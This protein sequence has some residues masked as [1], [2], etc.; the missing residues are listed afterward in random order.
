M[1]IH[2]RA[3]LAVLTMGVSTLG[4]SSA[5][6]SAQDV[7]INEFHYDNDGIDTGEAIEV[8]GV[9]GT[10]LTGWS[11]VLYN[12]STGAVYD[13]AALS[14]V[15]PQSCT[16]PEIGVTVA[17]FPTN[18]IQNGS[19]DGIALVSP[20]G[21]VVQ[22]L[23]YEGT[24]V[25]VGGPANGLLST[26]IGVSE[27]SATPIGD[28]LQ[29][30]ATGWAAG[31]STFGQCN[32]DQVEPPEL[33][34][35]FINEFHYDNGGIDTGEAIEVAGV[36]GTEVTGWSL[37]L[38]SGATGAV[39]DT[40][41]PSGVFPQSCTEPEVGVAVVSFPTNGIQNG[42]PDGIALVSPLGEVVQFLSYEGTFVAV[43][44][45]ANGQLSTD[46]GVSESSATPIGDS[47][48]LGTTGWAAGLS[49]FGQC[50]PDQVPT[51][52]DPGDPD[53][54]EA[55]VHEI[56]GSGPE[57]TDT[58][59]IFQVEAIV[60]GDFQQS[61]QLR[62]FFIQEEDADVDSDPLT[63][64]GIFV[65]CSDCPVDVNV[66]D[67]V[68][69]TGLASDGFDM[70]QLTATDPTSVQVT[71]VSQPL[72]TPSTIG[73]PLAIS[74]G[75][76][77]GAEQGIN[78][79][80]EAFEGMLVQFV[81]PLTVD[82]YFQLSRFGQ[83]VLS[84]GSRPRQF[85]DTQTPSE[86]G[87]TQH[88]I[89]LAARRVI[90]DDDNNDRDSALF[91]GTPVFH[92]QP[93]YSIDNF[94]RGGDVIGNLTGV[95][96]WSSAGVGGT[97]AWRVRPVVE[98]FSYDFDRSSPRSE[99]P[100]DVGGSLK[101]A[102]FNV[103]NFFTTIDD[104]TSICGPTGGLGCR[105]ASSEAELQ[106]QTDKLASAL[107]DI[108][109]DIVG[110]VELENNDTASLEALVAAVSSAGCGD[111]MF[112]DT[113]ATG[114]DAIKV[115]L[116][117]KLSAVDAI[118]LTAVLD[119]ASFTDPASTGQQKNRPAVAQTFAELSS[120]QLL[121]VVVNHLKS[122]GSGCGPG[123]DSPET[124]VGS[125]NLTR[126]LAAEVQVDWLAAD[127]TDTG[128]ENILIIG[129]L[130]AYRKE[131]PIA[132]FQ[133]GGYVD[134][135]DLF[136]GPDAYSFLFDGQLGTLDYALASEALTPKVTGVTA[137]H[138]NADEANLLDYNDTVRD[139]S[140]ASF[141]PK[142]SALP[143]FEPNEYRSSDHDPLV[144]GL[145]LGPGVPRC[146]GLDATIYVDENGTIVGGP[147]SGAVYRGVLGATQGNDVIV[148]SNGRDFIFSGGGNDTICAGG[149]NDFVLAGGGHDYV[150]GEEG[151]DTL[152]G[153]FGNDAL[154]GGLGDDLLIGGPGS[155]FV[156]GGED[157]D[158]CAFAFAVNCE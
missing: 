58:T 50:N 31:L 60:V 100:A 126:T 115:G 96:H 148:A 73:L 16:E 158:F 35:V 130:N 38:Y 104:G 138:I 19:P 28:S 44:G 111:Y 42:S 79:F 102:S 13:T 4:L 82:E 132:A 99:A 14:G 88:Q 18:G 34:P 49:T 134:L 15:L 39:Y 142:P 136:L 153:G 106:R 81:D 98:A 84:E 101:V 70:S 53:P 95:L 105:G 63:S 41:A 69:V 118:G 51:G 24:F 33:T 6:A 12:G 83:L 92:P 17:S 122:K 56:Q 32:P 152:F 37:V 127:P 131:A 109:A 110:L 151:N 48:Q 71:A 76:L 87:F 97:E 29:L 27:P 62:G 141:E 3:A 123:D 10:D 139:P 86:G 8:A 150:E 2:I 114:T 85:T 40:A 22:F 65:S 66:R 108:D 5:V 67:R 68:I 129:D 20:L 144:I 94:V 21:G 91:N 116:I 54:V 124:G 146:N 30:G 93:G 154:L 156:D 9:P 61:D 137:W 121:T 119:D 77:G 25:A 140:E 90:L 1:R 55:F 117:Y 89:D 47:L 113:G 143:L 157:H 57:V 7:F 112:V 135:A 128:S 155:D 74:A 46:I 72:P 147:K 149:G 23:S 64:E 45:P 133:A 80:Y 75:D 11:L 43:G 36:P 145:D 52:T 107:C 103:L 125:C 120:G 59:T 26:D 78:A